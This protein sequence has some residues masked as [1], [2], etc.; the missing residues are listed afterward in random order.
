[1]LFLAA[2]VRLCVC[3]SRALLGQSMCLYRYGVW[4]QVAMWRPGSPQGMRNFW[5]TYQCVVN[6]RRNRVSLQNGRGDIPFGVDSG[7]I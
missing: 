5:G 2:T 4:T 7:T 1:M 3:W 6:V